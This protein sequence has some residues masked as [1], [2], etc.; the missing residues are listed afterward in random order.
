MSSGLS[1]VD[2]FCGA[3]GLSHGFL[4]EG[5]TINA[6]IDLDPTCRFPFTLNNLSEFIE[7]D[8]SDI[9]SA[10]ISSL[11]PKGDIKILA[12]CAPCQPFST[13]KQRKGGPQDKRWD[14]LYRFAE[15]IEGCLPE[16]VTMENVPRVVKH[17]V[18]LDFLRC[19]HTCKYHVTYD[20]VESCKYGVPQS[21]NRVVLLASRMGP[22]DLGSGI[23][24][25]SLW[26]TVRSTIGCLPMLNGGTC[27]PDD[28]LHTAQRLT[29]IN[30]RRIRASKPGGTWR[31]WPS[32]LRSPCHQKATG[33]N[34]VSV[35][36][37]MEWDKP[38]P[39]I[40]T[41]FNNYGSGRF[42]HPEQDRAI[43]LRE[44]AMLQSFPREYQFVQED[45]PVSIRTLAKL[46]GNA[47][48]VTLGSAIAKSI[49]NHVSAIPA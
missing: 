33:N 24:D 9:S 7:S 39:T 37:R 23:E 36:G 12:G 15:L 4:H 3:G 21:R 31:D 28:R 11:Y 25:S 1:A 48:P 20:I 19:L 43:S 8:I 32:E 46:I 29:E 26:P 13:Y 40:T 6:G 18:F 30:L 49:K 17:G 16:I 10:Q 5:I 45:D 42:G 44:A 41:Q 27:D 14:L 47:V 38:A 2:L 34:Y 35:Y 22:I